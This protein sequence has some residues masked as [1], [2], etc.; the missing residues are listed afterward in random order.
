MKFLTCD[1]AS[2]INPAYG[3]TSPLH[4]PHAYNWGAVSGHGDRRAWAVQT[5]TLFLRGDNADWVGN[6]AGILKA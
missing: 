5:P 4:S 2:N 6:K 3:I 1:R